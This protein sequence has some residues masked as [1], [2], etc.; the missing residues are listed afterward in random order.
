MQAHQLDVV[1][2]AAE[3]FSAA[4]RQLQ[5]AVDTANDLGLTIPGS[6]ADAIDHLQ[7]W[8]ASAHIEIRGLLDSIHPHTAQGAEAPDSEAAAIHRHGDS[9]QAEHL[10]GCSRG[11]TEGCHAVQGRC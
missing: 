3:M 1:A 9:G 6:L 8:T 10:G 5:A 2:N 4:R 11:P 7:E